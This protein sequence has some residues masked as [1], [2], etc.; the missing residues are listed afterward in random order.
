MFDQNKTQTISGTT[1]DGA[2][3][4]QTYISNFDY[5]HLRL[6]SSLR[7]FIA[8]PNRR[9]GKYA[10]NAISKRQAKGFRGYLIDAVVQNS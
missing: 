2:W 9:I 8:E 7:A 10:T 4:L 6:S 1:V 5:H 3:F